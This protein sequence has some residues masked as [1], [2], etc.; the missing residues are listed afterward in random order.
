MSR[1]TASLAVLQLTDTHFMA[2]AQQN[3]LGI[4]TEAYFLQVLEQAFARNQHYDV[5]VVSGDLA[6]DPCAASYQR[7]SRHLAAYQIPVLCLPGNHDD[8]LLMQR[9]L[10]TGHCSCAKQHV[11]EHWQIICLNSQIV[12]EPGGYLARNELRQL[13][14]M[15]HAYPEHHALIAV[16]HHAVPTDSEW[17]DT[18]MI[19]NRE[20]FLQVLQANTQAK[21][22]I[23]G[24]I[25]QEFSQT[26]G[27]LRILGSPSTCFQFTPRS[28]DFSIARTAPGYR[29][30]TLHV[31]GTLETRV[32][33]LDVVLHELAL[34]QGY[35]NH[36]H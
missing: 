33:R 6:Q 20:D 12:D 28:H 5:I 7:L 36:N 21:V 19:S 15:L 25:H 13:E 4:N 3:M 2:D 34:D 1:T 17:M 23:N 8:V 31:D 24:H 9:W 16:H 35:L 18:M 10:N 26:I 29:S 32:D 11:F 14:Q 30:L 27:H 22:L